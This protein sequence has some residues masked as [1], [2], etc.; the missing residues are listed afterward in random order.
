M[1]A[2]CRLRPK[3]QQHLMTPIGI[4][5]QVATVKAF[6]QMRPWRSLPPFR[7]SEGVLVLSK[8]R[9]REG[10]E[11]GLPRWYKTISEQKKRRAQNEATAMAMIAQIG[12]KRYRVALEMLDVVEDVVIDDGL[13]EVLGD[14][15]PTV[16]F[17]DPPELPEELPEDPPEE[18]EVEESLELLL[19]PLDP[20]RP[21]PPRGLR[22]S[23]GR[24]SS[25]GMSMTDRFM[26]R[27]RRFVAGMMRG[28]IIVYASCQWPKR[29]SVCG[30]PDSGDRRFISQR[31]RIDIPTNGEPI[32]V[33]PLTIFICGVRVTVQFLLPLPRAYCFQA[34]FPPRRRSRG[35]RAAEDARYQSSPV[36]RSHD[37]RH[38]QARRVYDRLQL[39]GCWVAHVGMSWQG[40]IAL[41]RGK[42]CECRNVVLTPCRTGLIAWKSGA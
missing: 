27:A 29:V 30:H 11:R 28:S 42:L 4:Q 26:D 38:I 12:R 37:M 13:D 14:D 15:E 33:V 8:L 25:V 7:R 17:E 23:S 35:H 34:A 24:K 1:V 32:G 6:H 21:P 40:T 20:P 10:G 3:Q 9:R 2:S 5:S 18:S 19:L 22:S 36:C 16:E 41:N 31:T 39:K